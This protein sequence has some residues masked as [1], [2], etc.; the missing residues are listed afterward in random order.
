MSPELEGDT[1][2]LPRSSTA[3]PFEW[4]CIRERPLLV[5]SG[6]R[7]AHVLL[8]GLAESPTG[9]SR[10]MSLVPCHLPRGGCRAS[11]MAL[12]VQRCLDV[13]DSA[14]MGRFSLVPW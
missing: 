1:R 3:H 8:G 12:P 9:R 11:Q 6:T 7:L 14:L 4:R 10:P 13:P 2:R 5:A